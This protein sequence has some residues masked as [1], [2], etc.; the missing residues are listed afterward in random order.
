MISDLYIRGVRLEKD[1][2]DESY[3][4]DLPMVSDELPTV[5]QLQNEVR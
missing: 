4:C 5:P 3:L 2:P 1:I